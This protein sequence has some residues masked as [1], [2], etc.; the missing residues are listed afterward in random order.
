MIQKSLSS[1]VLACIIVAWSTMGAV[2]VIR[3]LP[4]VGRLVLEAKKPFAC[5]LCMS[6][7]TSIAICGIASW[8]FQ[9]LLW[10]VCVL[11]SVATGVWTLG[12][13]YPAP[14]GGSFPPL[15]GEEP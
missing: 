15:P 9:D 8:L 13:M 4:G 10:F 14:S 3:A 2:L 6:W 5:D 1:M 11:P 7:W 12:R